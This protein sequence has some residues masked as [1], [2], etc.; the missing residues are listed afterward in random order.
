MSDQPDIIGPWQ[1]P[2][3]TA[4][5][6]KRKTAAV[7]LGVVLV[8]LA[9]GGITYAVATAGPSDS[10]IAAEKK[11][12]AA[13]EA[14]H[15]RQLD[16]EACQEEI[17]DYLDALMVIDARLDVGLNVGDLGELAGLASVEKARVNNDDLSEDCQDAISKADIAMVA[18]ATTASEWDDCIW[19]DYCDP[20]DLDMQSSWSVASDQIEEAEALMVGEGTGEDS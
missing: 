12:K 16:V 2:A 15:Q 8:V 4:E 10:E 11:A 14:E 3:P 17:G 20:D 1:H 13:E 19:A 9:T 5:P 18:Y 6:R 7:V